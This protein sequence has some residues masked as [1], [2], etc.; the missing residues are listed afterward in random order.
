[1]GG[2]VGRAFG[3]C[4]QVG[5]EGVAVVGG[6]APD[7][8]WSA[9]HRVRHGVSVDLVVGDRAGVGGPLLGVGAGDRVSPLTLPTSPVVTQCLKVCASPLAV[10]VNSH[11]RVCFRFAAESGETASVRAIEARRA[12][13]ISGFIGACFLAEKSRLPVALRRRSRKSRRSGSN[14]FLG[15]A[16][17][18]GLRRQGGDD[19]AQEGIHVLRGPKDRRDVGLQNDCDGPGPN[20]PS[21]LVWPGKPIIKPILSSEVIGGRADSSTG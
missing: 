4:R 16:G 9:D 6:G 20:A 19:R 14:R 3:F 17:S 11:C 15:N 8:L 7:G 12:V 10:L 2:N 13:G 18:L 1:M 21:K 5:F